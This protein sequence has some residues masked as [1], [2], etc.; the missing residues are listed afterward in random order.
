MIEVLKYIFALI[1]LGFLPIYVI[2]KGINNIRKSYFKEIKNKEVEEIRKIANAESYK[3]YET[4]LPFLKYNALSLLK[5]IL[6]SKEF[7][8]K[9][10]AYL[11]GAILHEIGHTKK[12]HHIISILYFTPILYLF[13][14]NINLLIKAIII[15]PAIIIFIR[16]GQKF[17]KQADEY[18]FNLIGKDAIKPLEFLYENKCRSMRGYILNFILYLK[19]SPDKDLED[20]ISSLNSLLNK[21]SKK[22]S[23][24]E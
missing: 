15:I 10:G 11:K 22:G 19:F 18:A 24:K 23:D 20:R 21:E 16:I 9:G 8:E 17:Q 6:V 7:V 2:L 13:Y 3:I 14:A 12:K 1:T 4:N 5:I